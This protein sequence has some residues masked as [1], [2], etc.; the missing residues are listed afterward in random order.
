MNIPDLLSIDVSQINYSL[1]GAVKK[2]I[3]INNEKDVR[4]KTLGN[5]LKTLKTF[6]NIAD[7]TDVTDVSTS[8]ITV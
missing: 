4:L 2:L 1:Y 6:L 5:R 7:V 8:N 3:E